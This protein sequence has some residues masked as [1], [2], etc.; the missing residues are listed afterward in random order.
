MS[1]L[2]SST[3]APVQAPGRPAAVR[4]PEPP[5][6]SRKWVILGTLAM[7]VAAAVIGYVRWSRSVAQEQAQAAGQ[8][9]K[10][11]KAFVGPLEIPLRMA[12]QTSSRNF[13]NV[14]TPIMRGPEARGSMTLLKLTKSG[15]HV[16]KG[17]LIAQIDAQSV[18]DHIDDLKD[19]IATAENDIKKRASEQSVEWETMQQT[20]RTAKAAYDKAKID[21]AAAEIRTPIERE[22]LKLTMD[23]AESRYKQQLGDAAQ[24]RQS[25]AS[26]RRILDITLDRH[27]RHIGRHVHDLEKFTIYAPM[28]GLAVMSQVFRGGEMAQIQQGDQVSP[29]QQI[30][31][32]VDPKNMQAE[33]TVSQADAGD[34]RL[35]QPVRVGFDA[36]PDLKLSGKVYALGA[37]AQGGW[38]N[39]TFVRTVAVRVAIDGS[40]PRLIPDLSAHCDVVLE[41]VP[42]QLQVPISAVHEENGKASVMVRQGEGWTQRP[43]TVGK[44]NNTYIAVASGLSAGDEVR[45]N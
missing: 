35:S 36:F 7:V 33:A 21:Y 19:T 41:T 11:A 34:L 3:P 14:V 25:Q 4:A 23:E 27:K 18:E 20:I 1:A 22:L 10:T 17:E 44:H 8:A 13:V 5:K 42:N 45:T 16:K 12:G 24:R 37:L 32:V 30:M 43:V 31:K 2:S 38:R 6:H 26:E 40:D 15:A 28:D 9:V 29:G 39:S